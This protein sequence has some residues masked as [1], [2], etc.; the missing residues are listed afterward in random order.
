MATS[1]PTSVS[2]GGSL[3]LSIFD[4]T[5][6]EGAASQTVA[7]SGGR[8]WA[9]LAQSQDTTGAMMM[10][11]PRYSVSLSGSVSTITIYTQ[12]GITTG[13]LVVIHS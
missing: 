6:T 4:F 11:N 13:E 9:V 1:N 12:E 5:A 8:V 7:V 3:K 10:H 2:I